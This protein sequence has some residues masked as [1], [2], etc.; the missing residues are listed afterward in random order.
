M[1]IC[2]IGGEPGR[3][4]PQYFSQC[5]FQIDTAPEPVERESQERLA[6]YDLIVLDAAQSGEDAWVLLRQI[7]SSFSVPILVLTAAGDWAGQVHAFDLGADDCLGT[8]FRQEELVA[9]IKSILRR[10]APAKPQWLSVGDLRLCPGSRKAHHGDRSLS[11]TAME[12]VILELLMRECGRVVSRDQISLQLYGRTAT[13][14]ERSV[15][16]HVSRIRRKLREGGRLIVSVRGSGYQLCFSQSPAK[17][18]ST[19]S[20]SPIR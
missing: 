8:P 13:A 14:F 1:R 11:V 5:G 7:R 17:T 18:D 10:A 3:V 20:P 9:R 6:S 19:M 4:S 15:D 12:C 16:T 2:F